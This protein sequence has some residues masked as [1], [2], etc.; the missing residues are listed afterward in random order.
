MSERTA[1]GGG[2]CAL[3]RGAIGPVGRDADGPPLLA[4][5]LRVGGED[6]S[7][8][9]EIVVEAR[10][11]AMHRSDERPGSAA[12]RSEPQASAEFR[13]RL[14]HVILPAAL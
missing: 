5:A 9:L 8:D 12:D 4:R 7:D 6:R 1:A 3:V 2:S 14:V 11:G 10:R 13:D